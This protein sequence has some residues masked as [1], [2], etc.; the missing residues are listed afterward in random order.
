L[1]VPTYENSGVPIFKACVFQGS[2]VWCFTLFKAFQLGV[3]YFSF[4]ISKVGLN[5]SQNLA[6]LI[7]FTLETQKR[8]FLNFLVPKMKKIVGR[9]NI[10][11]GHHL[12][13]S[14]LFYIP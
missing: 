2:S 10:Q 11:D 9:P 8:E 12:T 13:F 7:E 5:F 4:V 14:N 6:T 1:I 3:F